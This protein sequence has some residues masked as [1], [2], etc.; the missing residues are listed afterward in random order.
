MEERGIWDYIFLKF[1]V[2]EMKKNV[3]V[4]GN[5]FYSMY[6]RFFWSL[7]V[8]KEKYLIVC[9]FYFLGVVSRVLFIFYDLFVE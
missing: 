1:R 9:L 4:Y 8:E 3:Y 2:L 5:V 7:L 6:L